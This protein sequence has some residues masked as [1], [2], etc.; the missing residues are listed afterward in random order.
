VLYLIDALAVCF[1][2][3]DLFCGLYFKL[4]SSGDELNLLFNLGEG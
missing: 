3:G 2:D 1:K 4:L